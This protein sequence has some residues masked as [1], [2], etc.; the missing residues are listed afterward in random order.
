MESEG[1]NVLRGTPQRDS[2]SGSGGDD[3]LYGEGAK[4]R[5][6][7]DSGHDRVFGGPGPDQIYSG[8]GSDRVR[9]GDADDFVNVLDETA[10]D[11]VNC[12]GGTF[13]EAYGDVGDT[14]ENCENTVSITITELSASPQKLGPEELQQQASEN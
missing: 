11:Y 2:L 7:G 5:L 9:A 12:G 10:N 4:D 1:D 6:Y 8:Q 13:D 3:R 14:Y